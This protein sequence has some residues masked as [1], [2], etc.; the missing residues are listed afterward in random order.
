[1]RA[2]LLHAY[3]TTEIGDAVRIEEVDSPVIEAADDLIVRVAG[4]GV[5]RTDLHILEGQK[6]G[7]GPVP[8]PHVL[9]H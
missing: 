8:L 5:C 9:G 2:A 7:E 1:M 6:F 4:A 3:T